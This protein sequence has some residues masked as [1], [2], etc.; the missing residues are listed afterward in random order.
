MDET[1]VLWREKKGPGFW[2]PRKNLA[3]LGL[4]ALEARDPNPISLGCL[5]LCI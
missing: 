4:K 5:T 1:I 2:E 3:A